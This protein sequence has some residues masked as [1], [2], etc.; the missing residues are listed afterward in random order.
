M[1]KH[2]SVK[3]GGNHRPYK[4]KGRLSARKCYQIW[5]RENLPAKPDPGTATWVKA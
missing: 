4:R 1:A 2:H 5:K 3:L